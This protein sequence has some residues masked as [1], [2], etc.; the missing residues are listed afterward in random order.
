LPEK[1]EGFT[2]HLIPAFAGTASAAL[3]YK[4]KRSTYFY[5]RLAL[6]FLSALHISIFE[7]PPKV[8]FSS[9]HRLK[10]LP[11]QVSDGCGFSGEKCLD[12]GRDIL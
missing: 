9:T 6:R 5:I 3:L 10:S 8:G 7:Q 4:P 12:K 11:Q 1:A 2:K